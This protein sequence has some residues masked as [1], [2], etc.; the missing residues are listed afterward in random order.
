MKKLLVIILFLVTS[1]IF[2]GSVL[3]ISVM[4]HDMPMKD[5]TISRLGGNSECFFNSSS[6]VVAVIEHISSIRSSILAI[7]GMNSSIF[8]SILSVT[9]FTFIIWIISKI[10][11]IQLF[12]QINKSRFFYHT[13]KAHFPFMPKFLLNWLKQKIRGQIALGWIRVYNNS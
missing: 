10:E 11:F 12:Q 8:L 7:V 1:T 9:I 4:N 3:S 5:C 13:N 2:V 6:W